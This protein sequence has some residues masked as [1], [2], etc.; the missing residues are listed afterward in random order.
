MANVLLLSS[1]ISSP[2]KVGRRESQAE[3]E[4]VYSH[5]EG[6]QLE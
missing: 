1:F 4:I 6:I 2:F 5:I 3:E